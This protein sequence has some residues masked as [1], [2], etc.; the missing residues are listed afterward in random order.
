MLQMISQY[1]FFCIRHRNKPAMCLM[2]GI[3]IHLVSAH[4]FFTNVTH[5]LLERDCWESLGRLQY[6]RESGVALNASPSSSTSSSFSSS[7]S[8]EEIQV[9][10]RCVCLCGRMKVRNHFSLLISS[11]LLQSSYLSLAS[12]IEEVVCNSDQDVLLIGTWK[13]RPDFRVGRPSFC[14]SLYVPPT[15]VPMSVCL[16]AGP[17]PVRK[18]REREF[19][20]GI[21]LLNFPNQ[22]H[23]ISCEFS[24]SLKLRT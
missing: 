22:R 20:N 10:W 12:I 21:L 2:E 3:Y 15:S 9:M 6:S 18:Y 17:K 23:N 1:S 14:F 13:I 4:F 5:L 11:L 16:S 19:E 24:L 7:S 8:L